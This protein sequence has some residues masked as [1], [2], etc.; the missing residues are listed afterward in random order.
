M[1]VKAVTRNKKEATSFPRSIG[2]ILM[3]ARTRSSSLFYFTSCRA[4]PASY[5]HLWEGGLHSAV[6]QRMMFVDY[7][8][9]TLLCLVPGCQPQELS[10]PDQQDHAAQNGVESAAWTW[11]E[12]GWPTLHFWL[13]R[14]DNLANVPVSQ[15]TGP[16]NCVN[17]LQC[18]CIS[19][20]AHT[21]THTHTLILAV[22]KIQSQSWCNKSSAQTCQL[23]MILH[24]MTRRW[25][26]AA[27]IESNI[28]SVPKSLRCRMT[29]VHGS[30]LQQ[31]ARSNL[32]NCLWQMTRCVTAFLWVCEDFK[33]AVPK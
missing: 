1:E 28:E 12:V 33:S 24:A 31:L 14:V 8:L 5:V 15:D 26:G 9:W 7:N 23:L 20:S 27:D 22:G 6:Q 13:K 18:A 4:M 29:Y 21:H 32:N 17:L 2:D 19:E 30:M 10:R 25:G 3:K 16:G 11:S